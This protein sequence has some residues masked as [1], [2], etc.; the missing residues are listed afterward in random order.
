MLDVGGHEERTLYASMRG[1]M[2]VVLSVAIVH[3]R[4]YG[5]SDKG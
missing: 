5:R 2:V 3:L 1:V 4:D